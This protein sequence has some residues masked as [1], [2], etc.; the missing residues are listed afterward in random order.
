MNV[1]T[2]GLLEFCEKDVAKSYDNAVAKTHQH[3]EQEL[4]VNIAPRLNFSRVDIENIGNM[5]NESI[6]ADPET[7]R[8][9][10]A[11]IEAREERALRLKTG[12]GN[13]TDLS[14]KMNSLKA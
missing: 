8:A 6:S 13:L 12:K 11:R 7:Y 5:H 9:N 1:D 3:T 14:A 4:K 10:L 2:K